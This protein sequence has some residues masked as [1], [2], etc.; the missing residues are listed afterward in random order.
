VQHSVVN[1]QSAPSARQVAPHAP[2]VW[3]VGISQ[4]EL[5]HWSLPVQPPAVG[6]QHCG[7]VWK[8]HGG[9][10]AP[11]HVVPLQFAVQHSTSAVHPVSNVLQHCG[12]VL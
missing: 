8:V 12:V 2:T 5:Q 6:V 7:V 4:L 3:P 10:G 9:R 1:W 11:S